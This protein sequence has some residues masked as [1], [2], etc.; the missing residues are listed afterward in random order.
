MCD[1]IAAMLEDS[2]LASIVSSSNMAATSSSFESLGT[3]C[4]PSIDRLHVTSCWRT[5]TKDSS[6]ASIVSSSNMA[7]M[8]LSFE[9]LGTDCKPSIGL[10]SVP[11]SSIDHLY[12]L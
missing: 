4:K 8:S 5:I 12:H 9:S 3:D 2:S 6:L 1:V 11:R 10:Q 7:T